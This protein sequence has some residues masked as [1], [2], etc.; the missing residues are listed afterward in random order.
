MFESIGKIIYDP[1]RNGVSEPWSAIVEVDQ[2][3]ADYYRYHFLNH[4]KISLLKPNWKPHISLFRG[5]AE[6]RPEMESFWKEMGGKEIVFCYTQE[7]FWNESFVWINTY[8]PEFFYLREKMGLKDT[9]EDNETWGH[10]TI[11]KFRK[12]GQLGNFTDYNYPLP[13]RY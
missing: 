7:I 5:E 10:I 4:F 13:K 8:F 3:L 6:Y 1:V 9:H 2:D 12:E 11:G